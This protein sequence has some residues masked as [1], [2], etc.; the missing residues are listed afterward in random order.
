MLSRR[1]GHE[2]S[3]DACNLNC[4]YIRSS[5]TGQRWRTV[6]A[7]LTPSP[8]SLLAVAKPV[9]KYWAPDCLRCRCSLQSRSQL[10]LGSPQLA[11]PGTIE[12]IG[13][14]RCMTWLKRVRQSEAWPSS[15]VLPAQPLGSGLLWAA[16]CLRQWRIA[17]LSSTSNAWAS[18][19]AAV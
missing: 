16:G 19:T 1:Q 18:G 11:T 17:P 6:A 10:Q 5:A 2:M 8:T 9:S 3:A 7:L 12:P 4:A 15:A 14:V 13:T